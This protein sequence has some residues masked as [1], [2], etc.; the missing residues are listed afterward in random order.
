MQILCHKIRLVIDKGITM[1]Q[2]IQELIRKYEQ[3]IL[4][5]LD[6][7]TDLKPTDPLYALIEIKVLEKQESIND[8]RG[9]L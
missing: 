4:L 2:Q 7:K 3:D 5:L 9:I 8:L 6:R 1:Q